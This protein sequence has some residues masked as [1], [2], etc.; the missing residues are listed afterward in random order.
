LAEPKKVRGSSSKSKAALRELGAHPGD[1]EP[2]NIYNGPYGMYVKH[3]KT[4]ASIPE[5]KSVEEVT[6]EEALEWLEAKASTKKSG[7]KS[8]KSSSST[9]SKTT[10]AS[11][12]KT[13][14]TTKKTTKASSG[15]KGS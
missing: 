15:K 4:N 5:G 10:K 14:T 2:V 1:G 9:T 8:K 13:K 11:S 7:A 6:M 12:T 3:G